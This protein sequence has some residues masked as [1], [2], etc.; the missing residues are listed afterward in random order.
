MKKLLLILLCLPFFGVSQC[1]VGNCDDGYG[2]FLF[3]GE[4]KGDRYVGEWKNKE[5]NGMGTY[6]WDSGSQYVGEWKNGAQYG[7]GTY[8]WG[9]G[10]NT[11]DKYVG[12]WK[13]G[14]K[15]GQGINYLYSVITSL[16]EKQLKEKCICEF[17]N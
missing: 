6:Y 4:F 17:K 1:V 12:E 7:V 8:I 9:S 5:P 3:S 13:Y 2:V 11:G 16:G 15:H 14:K 10:N